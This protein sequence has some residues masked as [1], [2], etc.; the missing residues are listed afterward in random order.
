MDIKDVDIGGLVLRNGKVVLVDSIHLCNGILEHINQIPM[1]RFRPWTP[2]LD[3]QGRIV[4]PGGDSQLLEGEEAYVWFNKGRNFDD[5]GDEEYWTGPNT[6]WD[7][8][9]KREEYK[10]THFL[11]LGKAAERLLGSVEPSKVVESSEIV[12]GDF[13]TIDNGKE[14]VK[15]LP[16]GTVCEVLGVT[17][18]GV[19]VKDIDGTKRSRSFDHIELYAKAAEHQTYLDTEVPSGVEKL[20]F[21]DGGWGVPVE[22]DSW[23]NEDGLLCHWSK[24]DRAVDY[25]HGFKR[26]IVRKIEANEPT[27]LGH[28]SIAASCSPTAIGTAYPVGVKGNH[29]I[30]QEGQWIDW[31]G[32]KMPNLPDGT[33]LQIRFRDGDVQIRNGYTGRSGMQAY[34]NHDKNDPGSWEIVAYRVL[35]NLPEGERHEGR[36]DVPKKGESFLNLEGGVS[37]AL[38]DFD[39][40]E[41]GKRWILKPRTDNITKEAVEMTEEIASV[42]EYQS[43]NACDVLESMYQL[44]NLISQGEDM[45]DK[46]NEELLKEAPEQLGYERSVGVPRTGRFRKD[47][48]Y[49]PLTRTISKR[50]DLTETLNGG[51]RVI[52]R[53]KKSKL[54]KTFDVATFIPRWSLA[55]TWKPA[56]GA[57]FLLG[58]TTCAVGCAAHFLGYQFDPSVLMEKVGS[59]VEGLNQ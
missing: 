20:P 37:V 23:V 19:T 45:S 9:R 36:Y 14:V 27:K 34:W 5:P 35:P 46:T 55:N 39:C 52:Y 11:P 12:E 47:L 13:V 29:K 18:Y 48:F 50:G 26:V 51:R 31:T 28:V 2:T 53:K 38:M 8:S 4:W 15:Y 54:R 17:N 22:G 16:T 43:A 56:L 6:D 58:A 40:G 21:D 49:S 32:G 30:S 25:G 3:G 57:T 24:G 44:A 10:V 33:L 7:H 59:V 1:C 41:D 42:A